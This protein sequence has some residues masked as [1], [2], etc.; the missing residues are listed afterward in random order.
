MTMPKK[1]KS[2]SRLPAKGI[3]TF[4]KIT[5]LCL[6]LPVLLLVV[7]GMPLELTDQLKLGTR[8]VPFQFVHA[9]YGVDVPESAW[10]HHDVVQLGEMLFIGDRTVRTNGSLLAVNV[11]SG[12]QFVLTSREWLLVP[13]DL[14]I[15]IER[16]DYPARILRAGFAAGLPMIETRQGILTS[17]DYGASWQASSLN[18]APGA[19]PIPLAVSDEMRRAYGGSIITWERWLQDLH[20][21]RYFGAFGQWVMMAAGF[22]FVLLALTGFLVWFRSVRR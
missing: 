12:F 7:T 2:D 1:T 10:V 18:L 15:P 22:A 20:S 3:R 16:G 19:M 11:A 6:V 8:G 9:R 21:G 17:Q 5:G 13:D 4:H 14:E